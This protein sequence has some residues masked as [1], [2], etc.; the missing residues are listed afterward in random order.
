MTGG[1]AWEGHA[2]ASC[3]QN[4]HE[5]WARNAQKKTLGTAASPQ[6]RKSGVLGDCC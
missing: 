2:P 5:A 1:H 3:A 4:L 6:K